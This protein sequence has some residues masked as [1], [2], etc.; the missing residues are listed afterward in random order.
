M[1]VNHVLEHVFFGDPSYFRFA[2]ISNKKLEL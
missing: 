2:K 1:L